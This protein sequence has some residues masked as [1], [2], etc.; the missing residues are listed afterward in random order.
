MHTINIASINHSKVVNGGKGIQIL[1]L[2][3]TKISN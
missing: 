2:I 1:E 3:E